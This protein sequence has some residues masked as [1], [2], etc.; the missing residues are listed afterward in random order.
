MAANPLT[1]TSEQLPEYI[2]LKPAVQDADSI[3]E[4]FQNSPVK[5]VATNYMDHP[6]G[7]L[8][9]NY[10]AQKM[11]PILKD[12][13]IDGG[14]MGFEMYEKHEFSEIRFSDQK[15]V[16][17]KVFSKP[18]WGMDFLFKKLNWLEI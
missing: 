17:T 7:Q 13:L 8:G 12:R 11:K 2:V 16:P 5:F 4:R 3:V 15:G 6:V 10:W 1:V 18:A 14:L 9:A